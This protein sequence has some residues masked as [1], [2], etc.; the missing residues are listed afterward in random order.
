MKSD[1]LN[2]GAICDK[3]LPAMLIA[4]AS[5]LDLPCILVPGGVT[6]PAEEGEDAGKVETPGIVR[7]L[8]HQSLR[9]RWV[10][11]RPLTRWL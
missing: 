4:L 6:L 3:G 10:G 1:L 9:G 7:C 5:S 2:I 8:E 11:K